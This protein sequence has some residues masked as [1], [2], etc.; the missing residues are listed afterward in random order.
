MEP[1]PSELL[2]SAARLIDRAQTQ[3]NL[4]EKSACSGCGSRVFE[5]QTHARVNERIVDQPKK[6]RDLATAL[7]LAVELEKQ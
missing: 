3:L 7:D 5:N 2:R 6:L 1:T 4:K